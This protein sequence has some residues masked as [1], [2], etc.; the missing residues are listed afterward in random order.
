[1]LLISWP[2]AKFLYIDIALLSSFTVNSN[3]VSAVYIMSHYIVMGIQL[4]NFLNRQNFLVM[5]VKAFKNFS[6]AKV[7]D[8]K[9]SEQ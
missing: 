3:G 5:Y 9:D 7:I 6:I 2:C 4:F 8:L 1:L